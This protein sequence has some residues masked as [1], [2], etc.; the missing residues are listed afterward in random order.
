MPK[1]LNNIF[2]VAALAALQSGASSGFHPMVSGYFRYDDPVPSLAHSP[3][4][5]TGTHNSEGL[6]DPEKKPE[7]ETADVT[8]GGVKPE[9]TGTADDY[10]EDDD[11][12][13]YDVSGVI[14]LGT[15]A[16]TTSTTPKAG[17]NTPAAQPI[18]A[19]VYVPD[20]PRIP[21]V[22][23]AYGHCASGQEPE[24]RYF[25]NQYTER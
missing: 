6:T 5:S 1:I 9:N 7:N 4:Q 15:Q 16:P 23:T 3:R 13:D 25:Y 11:D 21:K 2:L 24:L 14:T 19:A 20:A 22:C 17:I 12:D 18:E 10:D 8:P